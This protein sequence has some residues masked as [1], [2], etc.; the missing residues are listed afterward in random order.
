MGHK[1]CTTRE[2]HQIT[3]PTALEGQQMCKDFKDRDS[4][5]LG[6]LPGNIQWSQEQDYVITVTTIVA[7]KVSVIVTIIVGS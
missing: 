4:L 1:Q 3:T 6:M 7:I 2:G 5:C